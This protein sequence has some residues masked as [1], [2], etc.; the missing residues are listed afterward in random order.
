MGR[1][2]Q[3]A[4]EEARLGTADRP[5][6][7]P[8]PLAAGAGITGWIRPD[9]GVD[10]LYRCDYA[11][12]AEDHHR[13]ARVTGTAAAGTGA[14]GLRASHVAVAWRTAQKAIAGE[15]CEGLAPADAPPAVPAR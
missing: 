10:L 14:D 9:A 1:P 6:Q 12:R 11:G 4:F 2:D 8:R 13:R 7:P 3:A 5:D 15:H